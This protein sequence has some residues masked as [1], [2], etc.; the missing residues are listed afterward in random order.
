ML[1]LSGVMDPLGLA[2]ENFNSV[3]QYRATDPATRDVIDAAVQLPDGTTISGPDDSAPRACRTARP[4]VRA[5][6]DRK[7]DG[8][9]RWAK[10]RLATC[11]R[12][13]RI[14]KKA[15]ADDTVSSQSCLGARAMR[16]GK[17]E[18]ESG[19]ERVLKT[20]SNWWWLLVSG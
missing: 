9:M 3:G 10:S 12:V 19:A 2:L 5:H 17:R 8:P 14:V 1:R 18:A 15:A 20:A 6:A 13:R 11:P 4:P 7:P 16:S